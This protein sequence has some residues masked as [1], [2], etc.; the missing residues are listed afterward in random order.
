LVLQQLKDPAHGGRLKDLADRYRLRRDN[1]DAALRRHFGDLAMWQTP[2]GG[3][4][5]WLTLHHLIDTRLL[6]PKAI[7]AGVAFMPGESFMPATVGG[8]GQLRLNF[9]HANDA[10][11]D[12]GLGKLA[13]LVREMG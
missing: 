7:K 4:F 10:Q 12:T 1:F 2:P 6:M 3:L 13:S 9:S 5:F 8:C 11:A